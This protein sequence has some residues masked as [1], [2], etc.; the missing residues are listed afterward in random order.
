MTSAV[1]VVP[2]PSCAYSPYLLV[3]LQTEAIADFVAPM[4][5]FCRS[6]FHFSHVWDP[7]TPMT[8]SSEAVDMQNTGQLPLEFVV[9]TQVSSI[10][11]ITYTLMVTQSNNLV[12]VSRVKS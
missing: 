7:E 8:P 9:R 10:K 12:D 5:Q 4:L 2:S 6:S 1:V 11:H 3:C